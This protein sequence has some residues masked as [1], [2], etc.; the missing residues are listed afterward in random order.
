[1]GHLE[2]A[3]IDNPRAVLPAFVQEHID[4][5]VLPNLLTGTD[6]KTRMARYYY[7]NGKKPAISDLRFVDAE[8]VECIVHLSIC[9]DT[10]D[11]QLDVLLQK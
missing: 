5:Y 1:M 7:W 8:G 6:K 3:N 4:K 10:L 2:Y 11:P 9:V